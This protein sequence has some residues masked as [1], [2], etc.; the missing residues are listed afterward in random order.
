MQ[1]FT[2]RRVAALWVITLAFCVGLGAHAVRAADLDTP[3]AFDIA[4]Q[5]L[6]AALLE[7]SKQASIQLVLD[8]SAV[9]ANVSVLPST[10]VNEWLDFTSN[11]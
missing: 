2:I 7:L 9:A 5:P 1:D 6:E 4:A 8:S 3:I 10:A 11:L